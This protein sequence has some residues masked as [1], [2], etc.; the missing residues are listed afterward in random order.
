MTRDP[1][2]VASSQPTPLERP[3]FAPHSPSDDD[4]ALRLEAD[5]HRAAAQQ[6]LKEGKNGAAISS[7]QHAMRLLE[8]ADQ[9]SAGSQNWRPQL[10]DCHRLLG[11]AWLA[12]REIGSAIEEYRRAITLHDNYFQR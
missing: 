3:V 4:V 12:R 11:D 2:T 10:V 9:Q 5:Q 8:Q 1:S 6:F 7:A